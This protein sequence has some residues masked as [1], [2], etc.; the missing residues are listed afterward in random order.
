MTKGLRI[1][2]KGYLQRLKNKNFQG[3]ELESYETEP[4]GE[5]REYVVN[6]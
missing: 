2:S 4:Y 1:N 5:D 6:N 3:Y